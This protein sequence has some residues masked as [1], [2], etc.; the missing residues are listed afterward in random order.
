MSIEQARLLR[1]TLHVKSRIIPN[2]IL[3]RSNIWLT[4]HT[5]SDHPPLQFWAIPSGQS[6]SFLNSLNGSDLTVSF[7]MSTYNSITNKSKPRVYAV[8]SNLPIIH[9]SITAQT[10]VLHDIQP[11]W[12]KST[13]RS[14][15]HCHTTLLI[16]ISSQSLS[17]S[18]ASSQATKMSLV[19]YVVGLLEA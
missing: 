1:S 3:P 2:N 15:P 4:H 19:G 8:I 6:H 9:A 14:S 16:T 11:H 13:H 18:L 17:T 10:V 5:T 7:P 12:N